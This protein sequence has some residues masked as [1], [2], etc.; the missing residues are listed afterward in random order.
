M[1]R[2]LRL[3]RSRWVLAEL[4]LACAVLASPAAWCAPN[5]RDSIPAPAGAERVM[6]VV[7]PPDSP[8]VPLLRAELVELGLEPADNA[9]AGR[10]PI[11]IHV[12]VG[13]GRLEV[14]IADEALGR[15]ALHEV[16]TQPDGAPIEHRTAVIH[17]VE[18][19]RWYLRGG[20][21]STAPSRAAGTSPT[22]SAP[23]SAEPTSRPRSDLR[24]AA[25]GLALYSPGGSSAGLGGELDVLGRYGAVGLRLS[26]ATTLLPNRLSRSTGSATIRT[27]V[28]GLEAVWLVPSAGRG[29]SGELGLGSGLVSTLLEGGAN[30]GFVAHDDHLL[31]VAPIADARLRLPLFDELELV[32]A[33]MLLVPLRSD[34][35]RFA[36][37]TV[38][39]YGQVLLSAGLGVELTLR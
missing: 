20:V 18:L 17:A 10:A 19:L 13:P 16:F 12:V 9:G 39:R 21:S 3:S 23:E 1:S 2:R 38:G 15:T 24:V 7:S 27:R 35:I 30:D 8:I 34:R 11:S 6:I 33:G 28:I 14:W 26:G 31:T 32:A 36:G 29:L 4:A 22:R 37:T 5:T 25:L